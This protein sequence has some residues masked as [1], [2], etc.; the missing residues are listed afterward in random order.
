MGRERDEWWASPFRHV[1]L[2]QAW[3]C[4]PLDSRFR[5][6]H[7]LLAARAKGGLNRRRQPAGAREAGQG[8]WSSRRR[9]AG[10]YV[11][12]P[13]RLGGGRF[14]RR[15]VYISQQSQS[16]TEHEG[17]GGGRRRRRP[18]EQWLWDCRA[19]P[20]RRQNPPLFFSARAPTSALRIRGPRFRHNG[21]VPRPLCAREVALSPRGDQ[22]PPFLLLTFHRVRR[23]PCA[24]SSTCSSPSSARASVCSSREARRRARGRGERTRA[25]R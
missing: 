10:E 2:G 5:F 17:G 20:I 8:K 12:P 13:F 9:S 22:E 3:A 25:Q 11:N 16:A 24:S 14:E 19:L 7:N 21:C 1:I 15:A 6:T 4:S 23:R 18:W